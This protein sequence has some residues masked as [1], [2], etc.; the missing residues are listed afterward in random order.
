MKSNKSQVM[1]V[2]LFLVLLGLT[3]A[4]YKHFVLGFPLF[5]GEKAEI[6]DVE[7]QIQFRGDSGPVSVS[8]AMPEPGSKFSVLD[9]MYAAPGYGFRTIG[10]DGIER[11]EWTRREA[12]G[13]QTIYYKIKVEDTL[14]E[15]ARVEDEDTLSEPTENTDAVF[16][17]PSLEGAYK[18]AADGIVA[19][20]QAESS[21][22]LSFVALLIRGLNE[23]EFSPEAR[24]LEDLLSGN[25]DYTRIDVTMRL[26]QDAGVP[27][28]K[29]RGVLL[30]DTRR[31]QPLVDM[32]E[33]HV[34][35]HWTMF[36]PETGEEG[37][38]GN[39]LPWQRGGVSL[40]DVTGGYNS[41]VT[42][43]AISRSVPLEELAVEQGRQARTAL[44]DF[45][46]YAL[47]IEEQNAYRYILL[48]PIG[49][50]IVVL[51]RILVGL[52]T[53][54][55]FMPVLIALAFLQT[56]LL[57][58]LVIFL[59]IIAIGL[60]IRF[61]LSRLNLLLVARISS[62]VIVVVG[63]MGAMSLLS[64]KLGIQQA[65]SVTFFP[66]IILAW[67]IERMSILWE[68]EGPKD[69]FVS[70]GGSLAVAVLSYFAMTNGFVEHLTFNFPEL[71]LVI[72]GFTLLLGQYT[73]YR[74][75]EL[76]RFRPMIEER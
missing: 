1:L 10:Q 49:T 48:V 4:G 61:I 7:A 45:S 52:K 23:V 40:L 3:V 70:G 32:V 68:E 37:A 55:T 64:Y 31:N 14:P 47:P 2:V 42:F 39:F 62:V 46:L 36:N 27:V 12:S 9:T 34:D 8:L 24:F 65:M 67:T 72:L 19:N 28:R 22:Q 25:S 41:R 75:L 18:A 38:P 53:S 73:G 6:W 59:T 5:P 57:P 20:A 11:A 44:V 63:I 15:L 43:S 29:V 16:F 60:W 33:V 50:L 69:V 13:R 76:K 54:G 71:L 74:L 66:M 26:L 56:K 30:E 21:D 51:M 58:G 17:S 35:G